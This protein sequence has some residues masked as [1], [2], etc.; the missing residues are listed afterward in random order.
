MCYP[1]MV[2]AGQSQHIR[3]M[4]AAQAM[5]LI[6]L[7]CIKGRVMDIPKDLDP[8]FL[9]KVP[10]VI[11]GPKATSGAQAWPGQDPLPEP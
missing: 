9:P 5:H 6:T 2:P 1:G 10:G 8:K 4:K 3:E 11:Q 7:N